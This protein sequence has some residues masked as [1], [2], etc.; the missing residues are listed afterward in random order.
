MSKTRTPAPITG[1]GADDLRQEIEA[2]LLQASRER[3]VIEEARAISEARLIKAAW[4][5]VLY[6]KPTRRRRQRVAA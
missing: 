5:A 1:T 4:T 6:R 3:W 2:I